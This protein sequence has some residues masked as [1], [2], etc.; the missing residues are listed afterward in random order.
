MQKL[1]GRTF[2]ITGASGNLGRA[3]RDVL[4][5]D[6]ANVALLDRSE[7]SEIESSHP[8]R[9]LHLG[10]LDLTDGTVVGQALD[11]A[12]A[13]FGEVHGLVATV[14]AFEMGGTS[15]KDDWT[16]WDAMLTANLKTAV[17]AAQAIIP[18]LP[19][20]GGRIITVSAG[21]GI[22]GAKG[23][24]AY[25]A[26]KSAVLR[27]TE[28]LSGELKHKGIT[29]NSVL[30]S[31][32]DTPQNRQA[33]PDADHSQWVPARDI[34]EVIAFLLSDAARSVTGALIPVY[35]KV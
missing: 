28:S 4:L 5:T 19:P 20:E 29:V 24:S 27:L 35:G 15:A 22:A 25:S 26:S 7:R 18:R 1:S 34:A 21:P 10:G 9:T 3:V 12:I 33:M 11:K 17:A 6:G 13:R 16:V 14:G 32:I 8:D 30:P 23:M 2:A 31:I